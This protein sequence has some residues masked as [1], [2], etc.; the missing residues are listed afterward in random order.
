MGTGELVL[1]A[2]VAAIYKV[3]GQDWCWGVALGEEDYPLFFAHEL[4]VSPFLFNFRSG[5]DVTVPNGTDLR[6]V[7]SQHI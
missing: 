7:L 4:R 6:K 1:L 2:S 5:D 3:G